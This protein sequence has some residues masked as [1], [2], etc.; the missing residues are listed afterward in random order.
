MRKTTLMAMGIVTA[1]VSVADVDASAE[2]TS[3][4]MTLDIESGVR[5]GAEG[6]DFTYD[7]L[8]FG[9]TNVDYRILVN[10][11]PLSTGSGAGTIAWRPQTV[12]NFVVTYQAFVE[13]MKVGDDLTA[14]FRIA[15]KDLAGAVITLGTEEAVYDGTPQIPP[16]KVVYQSETLVEGV[17]Y[18][19]D[20]ENNVMPGVA[21]VVIRGRGR[22][23][24]VV[25]KNFSIRPSGISFL[26][27]GSGTRTAAPVEPLAYDTAWFGDVADAC[28]IFVDGRKL[29]SGTGVGTYDWASRVV[30][31][32]VLQY[33]SY[34]GDYLEDDSYRATFHVAGRDLVN[35]TVTVNEKSIRYD[36]TAHTPTLTL[37]LDGRTL[38]PGVDYVLSYA[39][40]V[41][42]GIGVITVTGL[43]SYVD[44][45]NV[46]FTIMPAG[47][48]FLDIESGTRQAKNIEPLYYD[49]AW[50]GNETGAVRM[51]LLSQKSDAAGPT[52]LADNLS[53]TGHYDFTPDQEGMYTVNL[54]TYV[55]GFLSP[56][57][58]TATFNFLELVKPIP[59]A[60]VTV[61]GY[62][63]A[64]DGAG[65]S[66]AVAVDPSITGATVRYG[67]T[68]D[69]VFGDK[70]L[71]TNVCAATTVW[72]E[73]S[74]A[75]YLPVTNSASVTIT[76]RTG[77]EVTITGCTATYPYD[78]R[79]KRAGGFDV[80]I[81]DP[82]YTAD[83]FVFTGN[84]NAVRT[85]VGTTAFGMSASDFANVN[86]DFADVVFHVVDGSVTVTPGAVVN[87]F[88]PDD[89]SAPSAPGAL[90]RADCVVVYDGEGHSISVAPL[91]NPALAADGAA[92]T[93]SL[94]PLRVPFA[95]ESPVFTNAVSTSV[96][97]RIASPNYAAFTT[98]ALLEIRPRP[99]TL[100]SG[101]KLDFVYDG[102]PHACPHFIKSGQDFVEGEGV[103]ASNWATVT[104]VDEGEVA[105]TF[106]YA[107]QEGTD[108]ANY[109]IAV[110]TG[111][112]AVVAAPIPVGPSG[113][114][115]AVGYT[116]VYDGAA[117][118]VAVSVARLLTTPTVQYR[119]DE[120]DVW[121]D[122]SPVFGDVCDTQVWYRV[123]APNYAPVVGS[124]G[125]RI[126]PRPVMLASK[127]ATKVYD[128]TPL[129]AHVVT[130]GGDGF[131]DGEGAAYAFTGS[132]TV[133]GTS[134]NTFTYNLNGNTKAGNY[135][136]ATV[137]G[138]LTVTKASIGG[139]EGDGNEPG[140]GEVPEGGLSKFDEAF[141]YDGEGHTIDTNA[142]TEAFVAALI[143]ES[144]VEYAAGGSQSPATVS[145]AMNS[146]PPCFTNAGEYV[147]WYR[148]TNPNC[149]DFVHRAKVTI[150]KR[151]V[152][153]T[154]GTKLDFVYDGQPH[155]CPHFIKSGHDFVEGEGIV[156]SNWATVTRVDEGEV[157]N[158]F[159][160]TAQEGTDLANYEITVVT[161]RIAVVAAPI[162]VGPSGAITAVGYTN[163]YDGAAHGIA[164]SAR[165]LLTPPTVQY[166]AREADAWSDASPVFRDV[167]DTQVWYRVSAPNYAPVVGSVGIRITPRP[168]TL[169]SK[170]ATKVYDGMPLTAHEVVVGGDGFADGE[171]AAYAFT[172]EQIAVGTSE[173]TFT[174]ALN[175]N[176]KA[177]NYAITMV[178]GT[179]TVTKA[180]IGGGEGDGGEPG[181]G[182][183]PD[184]GLSKF[185]VA[186]VYDGAGHTIDTNALVVAFGAA[187]IGENTVE[188]AAVR[189]QSPATVPGAMNC[190]PP[191]FTNAGEYVVWYKVTNPNYED[192][193]HR[194]KVTI[195]KRPVTLTSG[196]KLDFVYDGQPHACPHF[197]KS[198]HDFVEGEGIVASNWATV[199]RVDE[200]E[201]ANTF[202]YAT[203]EGT[204]LANYAITVVTG[205]I[206]V[207]KATY[208]M[209]NVAWNYAG[210]FTYDGTTKCVELAGLPEGVSAVY[211]DN[212]KSAVGTYVAKATFAYDAVNHHAPAV[213]DC[214]WEIAKAPI[215]P[216]GGVEPGDGEVPEG[217]LSRFDMVAMYDGTGH[218]VDTNGLVAAFSVVMGGGETWVDYG[219]A[220]AG[221]ATG[222]EQIDTWSGEP[223][224]YTNV[225]E[226]VVW[227]KVT[228][229]NYEDFVH[230]AKV[231][232]AKR[233]VTLTSGTKLDFVYDGQPHACPHFI[234]S[235]QGFVA[236]EGIV[237][238]NWAT[239][240]RV[241]EG[242][243]SNTFDYA[244]QEGTDLANYE[245][246]VVTG[247]IAVV[248]ASIPVGPNGAVTAVGYTNVYDGAAHGIAVSVAGLLTTPTVQYR[249]DEA[250]AWADVSPAFGDVCDTQVWYRVS[251][252]NYVPVVGSVG[253][254]ITP[255]PVTL[256]SKN[257]TKV[258]DGMPLTAHVVTV[259]GD[260]FADGE[261]ATYAFAG[262]QTIVGT[263]ENTFTYTLNENTSV[264]NYEISM[265]NGTL[266]VTKASIGGGE[267]DGNEPGDG[268]VPEGGLSKFDEA[269]VYDGEGHTIDTNALTEAFAA[270]L[271]G[272][273]AVEYVAGGSQSPATVSGAMNSIPPC[274]I[275][276]GEYVVWYKVTNPNYEDF[277]HRA[278]VTIAKRPV[279]LT[280]G[281]K[282]DFVYDGQPHACPHFI[283][284]GQGFVAGEGIVASNWATVTR[285]DEGEVA[286][287]FDYVA[288]EGTD[289]ANYEIAVV[290]G[291]IA[292][293]AA[294]IP[295]GPSG[296]ITAVGYTNVYDGAAHGV[297]VSASGLLTTPTYAYA[298]TE[299]G[300]W[301]ATSPVFTDVCDTQVWYR[302][303]APNYAPVVG[304][305]GIRIT[306]RPVML[307][308][309][310]A[311][312]VYDGTPL[313][314][315]VVTVG[316]DGFVDGEGAAYAFTGS[317]T[318]V[319]TS[320]NS[321]TYT[322]N[323]KTAA[324]N[325]DITVENGTLTVT[326]ASIGGGDGG[327]GEPGSG[328]I[329]GD[330][331][332][333]F[334][335]TAMYDGAG[336]TV[337]TNALVETFAGALVDAGEAKVYYGYAATG[338]AT[339]VVQVDT[340][341]EVPPVYT[342]AGEYVVW[343][344]VMNPN[345][346]DFT[347]RVRV[348]I[349]RRRVTVTSADGTWAYD[350]TAHSNAT[351]TVSGDGFVPGEGVACG[352]FAT[353]TNEGA[354]PNSFT[355]RLH[356]G[357]LAGNYEIT[358]VFGTLTVT[359][360]PPCRVALDALGGR[361][362]SAVAVTQAV[363]T[364][365][366][367][368]PEATRGGYR[369]AGWFLGV[370]NG[371]PE[372]VAGGDVLAPGDH[373]L[374][375]KWICDPE[376]VP[377]PEAVYTWEALDA[378]TVRIT[379]LRDPKQ[380]L[381]RM[382]LPDRIGGRFVT[383]VAAGAFANTA[384]GVEELWLP[385]FCT[386]IGDRAFL[387]IPSL[388][389]ITFAE[390]RRWEDPPVHAAVSI[391]RYAF[392][393]ATSL[394]RLVLVK[395]IASLGDYA[396]L[397]ARN[398][399]SV[400]ILGRP[401]LG[402]Q[403][404]RS[405]GVDAGGVTVRLNPALADDATY[406]EALTSGM[407]R[408]KIRTDAIVAGLRITVFELL[409]T[410]M[411][412]LVV[413]VER[414]ADWGVVNAD[415]LLV[416]SG[417][418]LP[419]M[420]DAARPLSAV[421]NG[422]GTVTLEVAA[423]DGGGF[424]Q[425]VITDE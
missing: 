179:L 290:T 405:C 79:E 10:G 363:R 251:A 403:V 72:C 228:N 286:N 231:T 399:T 360:A 322:L 92:V 305:V 178:N 217:G 326:K 167:C 137:N 410:G 8:W 413:S 71:F 400:T 401:T 112:I 297:V 404:F 234:K 23:S 67:L 26:D 425:A 240:T 387:G 152:T 299:D 42:P 316:G 7:T 352:G 285:V 196:T 115:T 114:I 265:V 35:A 277:V 102:Q 209:T 119:A 168:V 254:R 289:L 411:A 49:R 218:T 355:H 373:A 383:E 353:I 90:A 183:V 294:P 91:L 151:P 169:T 303:S 320:E 189:S 16:V 424:F 60:K 350:G 369:F 220:A 239:V 117:H 82:F 184:S 280:S 78:G 385:V 223:P 34:I 164:V 313:T 255:R 155:A 338:A 27:L 311:T 273:S 281:T 245:I 394:V 308:S 88:D 235:G 103:I 74:A 56:E 97:Y 132:Q 216:G 45:L 357:T 118:G 185:D 111:R 250:D 172:G 203:Q 159:D 225:G 193:V 347:H 332:S 30:G 57:V 108:L 260:G 191:C 142:L 32:H 44:I 409:E 58:Y 144:A 40:N 160:Y 293:V 170:S 215:G 287:T 327:G 175:G 95:P 317:Q 419:E 331:L 148:V 62:V 343:Y 3:A 241:D 262:S 204:D 126:T 348:T 128:G 17:D 412:R 381:S 263:S 206:A 177:D 279:T 264:D 181:D 36:G 150:T 140:D 330:G 31:D 143:G 101:T 207:V 198:G 379:G 227:Y 272:E 52:R 371:A 100:T 194:A 334:D 165:D 361:I 153:L 257:A 321:F 104:R 238:S 199:T 55:D 402:R 246:A 312:K 408:A 211:T 105:N 11:V 271:I 161:G 195:T 89:P 129:T 65:H 145:D 86:P 267:G 113:A 99:V 127:S 221:A 377:D 249:A 325:Y 259:G 19:L 202:T 135:E 236:G 368:L 315:H 47:V 41:N 390:A 73:I 33:R 397:N 123:S 366:G 77:V 15:G 51:K 131:V 407:S 53:G 406:R 374:F 166:R 14:S 156:A 300:E 80:A 370:T 38:V 46:P 314:A 391:G 269:F 351:V 275:N 158:T 358:A 68:R 147:V 274:F 416:R 339:G 81:S 222:V 382:V 232:I 336:H 226:Y 163:V 28:G 122:V 233:P 392:S 205:K 133:V 362:G 24:D 84:S 219:Y 284:S 380:R 344:R 268:E 29:M 146:I 120:A 335:T 187:M 270:A 138:T 422:D 149:E 4:P 346:E 22:F 25:G 96:W 186:F 87:P 359:A 141:V 318:V 43:G 121:A 384:C 176:M 110:V 182:E 356:A 378:D 298:A 324:G 6:G 125:I 63:G 423:P 261:G 398:L 154:S 13:G 418:T 212:E 328:E 208:D 367:A 323:E 389:A 54:N 139:G 83:D 364:I 213:A 162:P 192:F 180:S 247:R 266:T 230:R 372:A 354:R 2:W 415:T 244:A 340:W 237:A 124:V 5:D 310:S 37:E 157:P 12:G 414:A 282:L 242:E 93:Y 70:P 61:T 214:V 301:S 20:Y 396:F 421:R 292:V 253:I 337:D 174:Y 134:E 296:A 386:K 283:K 276:A 376:A 248:A 9:V 48:C 393:G 76:P 18:T 345:Y 306:P 106:D 256:A 200:G 116:N 136:I 291:R 98:N 224:V 258:Y 417:R 288:Q 252:P 85:A 69:G 50:N 109:E 319:G 243:V 304:S 307:A 39:D 295:V 188:Y 420:G 342:N 59:Q 349:T 341:S 388:R 107:A 365:Y 75:G 333:K 309:K 64:Y 66:I 171:G 21:T 210:P 1:L 329:P 302:V 201:V 173:N 375:A 197:I 94:D 130:V 229:P 190:V 278:K 395:E